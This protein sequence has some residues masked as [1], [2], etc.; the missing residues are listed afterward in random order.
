MRLLFRKRENKASGY[1]A[2]VAL[3][4]GSLIFPAAF[5][6]CKKVPD[7]IVQPEQM[8]Q[9]MADI[10]VAESVTEADIRNYPNDS[11]KQAL[12]QS[13]LLK[14][15]VTTAE[16]D[17]ALSWY[18]RNISFFMEVNDR[19]IEIL[20]QRLADSGSRVAAENALSVSGDSA[21]IWPNPRFYALSDRMPT[22]I[23]T[24]NFRKDQTWESG[25]S[26][27]WRA[28]FINTSD[29]S[30]WG[31]AA[32]YSDGTVEFVNAAVSG[33]GWR[34][35]MFVTDSTTEAPVKIYGYLD[36]SVPAALTVWLDSMQMIRNR[37][38]RSVYGRRYRQRRIPEYRKLATTHNKT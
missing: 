37:L 26:Y 25:D 32:E 20:E 11:T 10:N 36:V 6:A 14:H 9:L 34:E 8:A 24:F 4:V 35:V 7:N 2:A 33:D 1:L 23:L 30:T 21:D 18:G 17:S 12:K 28:K 29:N 16:F 3:F 15:G 13:V 5:F 22:K 19:T 31:I 27:T 38:D